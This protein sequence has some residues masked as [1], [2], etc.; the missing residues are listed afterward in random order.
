MPSAQSKSSRSPPRRSRKAAGARCAV[1]ME[2]EVPRKTRSRSTPGDSRSPLNH[3][4][5]NADIW[6]REGT[7]VNRVESTRRGAGRRMLERS[8]TLLQRFLLASA[9]ILVA[10]A[11]VLGWV[12]TGALHSQALE[13]ERASLVRYVDS[14]VRPTLI[15][16]D[17]VVLTRRGDAAM[18]RTLRSQPDVADGEGLA[19]RRHPRVDEPRPQPDRPPLPAGR[20]ARPG[21]P[22][23]PRG[24]GHHRHGRRG[25]E[26]RREA[27]RLL[28]PV[29]GVRADR[30]QRPAPTRSA[31][32]RSTPIRPRSIG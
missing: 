5:P 3:P 14:V 25:R 20:R 18:L 27:A 26:R 9:V 13:S 2:A 28:P 32:T 29:R 8:L 11:V 12:L 7:D 16:G 10:G 24:G 17:R 30:E 6:R 23:E 22:R 4:A 15:S 19:A 1:G 21:D 31:P